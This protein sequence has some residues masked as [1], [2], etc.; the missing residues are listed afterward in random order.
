LNDPSLAPEGGH[1]MSIVAQ[2]APYRLR[3]GD[4]PA[5]REAFADHVIETLAAY[6]PELPG[7]ILARQVLTPYDLERDFRVTGGH[8]HH[9]ELA[10]DHIFVLR[11]L[12]RFARYRTP[13][14]SL[15][16]C[17]AGA[18]PGGGVMGAAGLN[19]AR[20]II[21]DWRRGRTA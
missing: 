12:P 17:G 18:H 9:G 13:I 21:R 19:A 15:Y 8:W 11:P 5:R 2:F 16:L 14:D 20:E 3:D 10:L 1:V 6:A 7:R 4:W